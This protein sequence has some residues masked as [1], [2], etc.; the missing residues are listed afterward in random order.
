MFQP[1]A[2]AR[3]RLDLGLRRGELCLRVSQT[4]P[5]A[6]GIARIDA[7]ERIE[8]R[9]MPAWI[10][11]AAIVVLAVDFDQHRR[12]LAQQRN[13]CGLVVDERATAAVG[14]DDASDEQG[15][16][17]L[18]LDTIL[19]QQG[20]ECTDGRIEGRGDDGLCRTV[21][22]QPRFAT[23]PQ[24]QPEG[25]E[26]DRLTRTGFPGQHVEPGP[27]FEVKRLD[28]HHIANGQRGQHRRR[29]SAPT[30]RC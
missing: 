13:A 30:R 7:S 11:Q 17:R 18:D 21:A 19:F 15:F 26:Q 2:I 12:H 22:H 6:R 16:A 24:R 3:G 29:Y 28:Q 8:Q 9:A 10:E 4:Y 25:I 27:E 20:A 14:L 5:G 1:F 23:A